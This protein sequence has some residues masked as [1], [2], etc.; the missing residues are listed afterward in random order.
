MQ[1]RFC[2]HLEWDKLRALEPNALGVAVVIN[3]AKLAFELPILL[4]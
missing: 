2:I 1:N 4:V 3:I